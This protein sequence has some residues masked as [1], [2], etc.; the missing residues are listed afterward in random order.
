MG[1]M[2][3][4]QDVIQPI[5]AQQPSRTLHFLRLADAVRDRVQRGTVNL[6]GFQVLRGEAVLT[7]QVSVNM[8]LYFRKRKSLFGNLL[9]FSL[10]GAGLGV[11]LGVRGFRAGISS[12]GRRYVAASIPGSGLYL[13]HYFPHHAATV[14]RWSAT[15]RG[16]VL[17]AIPH[18]VPSEP[19]PHGV[20]FALG[21]IFGW[22]LILAPFVLIAFLLTRRLFP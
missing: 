3:I 9:R 15:P 1:R 22:A 21:Y 6:L 17:P 2:G 10:T 14:P 7:A 5:L 20:A 16:N 4:F 12:S 19:Q 11:S 13:R 18:P 8:S